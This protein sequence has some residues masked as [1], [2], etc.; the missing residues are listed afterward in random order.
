V[1]LVRGP[2]EGSF[3]ARFPDQTVST[4]GAGGCE[5][6]ALAG[7]E[8]DLGVF[9]AG[10]VGVPGGPLEDVAVGLLERHAARRRS[11]IPEA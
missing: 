1:H 11:M 3:E 2:T 4:D 8:V 7:E 5:V 6:A 9:L 10:C